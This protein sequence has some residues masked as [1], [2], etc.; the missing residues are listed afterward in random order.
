MSDL[1]LTIN[2]L[3]DLVLYLNIHQLFHAQIKTPKYVFNLD[4]PAVCGNQQVRGLIEA[5]NR[6]RSNIG[7]PSKLQMRA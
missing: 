4:L 2:A 6:G 5:V 3:L 7:T 1:S